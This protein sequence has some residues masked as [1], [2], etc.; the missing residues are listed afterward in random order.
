MES[1]VLRAKCAADAPGPRL[2]PPCLA[3]GLGQDAQSSQPLPNEEQYHLAH[4]PS[5]GTTLQ[6]CQL[7]D[8][9][10]P[11]GPGYS[12]AKAQMETCNQGE[13][14]SCGDSAQ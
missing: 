7:V 5:P 4:P 11:G 3:L 6:R 12:K 10:R 9:V 8:T 1:R 14:S 13:S 2:C